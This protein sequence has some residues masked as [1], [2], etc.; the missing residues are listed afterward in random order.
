MD[1]NS[2][3]IEIWRKLR[4]QA[5]ECLK[6]KLRNRSCV[7]AHIGRALLAYTRCD[8][9]IKILELNRDSLKKDTH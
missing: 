7:N 1:E 4:N 3:Q 5:D 8:H 6:E 9:T 2:N